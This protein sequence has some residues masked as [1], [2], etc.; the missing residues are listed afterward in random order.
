MVYWTGEQPRETSPLG[1][2]FEVCWQPDDECC[3]LACLAS[4]FDGSL[5]LVHDPE[6]R[7]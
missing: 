2:P 7:G 3:A 4:H 1:F 5:V 6:D